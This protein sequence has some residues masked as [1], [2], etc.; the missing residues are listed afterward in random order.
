MQACQGACVGDFDAPVAKTPARGG[1]GGFAAAG[2]APRCSP[3]RK[4][5]LPAQTHQTTMGQ[6][7]LT[8][9]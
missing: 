2:L 3:L 5:C 1:H 8:A 9:C 6:R 7:R 4:P